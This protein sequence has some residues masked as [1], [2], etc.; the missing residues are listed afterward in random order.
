MPK[1]TMNR[2]GLMRLPA[3]ADRL[4]NEWSGSAARVADHEIAVC[5]AAT[6]GV[7]G[8]IRV[9][10]LDHVAGRNPL[11]Q[12]FE[13]VCVL[14]RPAVQAAVFVFVHCASMRPER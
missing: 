2:T 12:V 7:A 13:P 4:M 9:G 10:R 3:P 8:G 1:P 5:V 6:L 14:L 11:R